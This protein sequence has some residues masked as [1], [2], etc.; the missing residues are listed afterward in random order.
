MQTCENNIIWCLF[1]KYTNAWSFTANIIS[2]FVTENRD[3]VV[4][5]EKFKLHQNKKNKLEIMWWGRWA[6]IFMN[7]LQVNSTIY[8]R[9][10]QHLIFS[11]WCYMVLNV[12]LYFPLF[13]GV[14]KDVISREIFHILMDNRL[15]SIN[16]TPTICLNEKLVIISFLCWKIHTLFNIVLWRLRTVLLQFPY[17]NFWLI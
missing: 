14:V 12:S 1:F 4:H 5:S 7:G 13:N 15:V 9:S 2:R 11:F 8:Q 6:F 10:C 16:G 17:R 3:Y